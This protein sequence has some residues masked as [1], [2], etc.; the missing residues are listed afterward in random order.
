[1]SPPPQL[2]YRTFSS[3]TKSADAVPLLPT[4]HTYSLA[5]S[6]PRFAFSRTLYKWNHMV[7]CLLNIAAF[8]QLQT[9]KTHP[10]GCLYQWNV[11]DTQYFIVCIYHS[12]FIL[13]G[14]KI[15]LVHNFL[16]LSR[17]KPTEIFTCSFLC[18]PMFSFILNT[19][20]S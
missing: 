11:I 9:F 3:V 2:I 16:Y 7:C 4:P 17:I 20:R 8:I 18:E 14:G 1:M 15:Q 12:S 10:C 5:T 19:Q 6:A 13:V